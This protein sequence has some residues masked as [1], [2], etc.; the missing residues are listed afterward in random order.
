MVICIVKGCAAS[1]FLRHF[2]TFA[3]F[4]YPSTICDGKYHIK[5]VRDLTTGHDSTQ[6]DGKAVLPT[7]RSSHMI[8]FAFA[9]GVMLTLRTS[10][11]EPK[12][13]YYSEMCA[14]PEER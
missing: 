4:Q 10:G 9:N 2:H 3:H 11:T 7:S 5:S 6:P 12:V 8:T 13:K 1:T 14:T